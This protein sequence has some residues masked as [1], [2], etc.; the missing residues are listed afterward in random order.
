MFS[1]MIRI[2]T[3]FIL[4]FFWISIGILELK[5]KKLL[6][7]PTMIVI[8]ILQLLQCFVLRWITSTLTFQQIIGGFTLI[9]F[10]VGTR[11]CVVGLTGGIACGKSAV[12]DQLKT[13][14]F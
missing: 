6:K 10:W 4:V 3:V 5:L 8:I 2:F 12:A 1:A 9:A 13:Q 14:G 7:F 11:M